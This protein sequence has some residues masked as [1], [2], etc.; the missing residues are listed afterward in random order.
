MN[1]HLSAPGEAIIAN[2]LIQSFLGNLV[3]YCRMIINI[4]DLHW[5]ISFV[6]ARS[7]LRLFRRATDGDGN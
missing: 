2:I 4:A 3:L 6:V 7:D 1:L 5:I